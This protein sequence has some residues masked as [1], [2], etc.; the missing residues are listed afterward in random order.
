MFT[1]RVQFDIDVIKNNDKLTRYYTGMPTFDSF[2]GLV[3]YLMPKAKDLISWN[4]RYSYHAKTTVI[5]TIIL[6]ELN[7]QISALQINFL[8]FW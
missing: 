4:G 5:W 6:L 7:F 8:H 3:E 2:M 1:P